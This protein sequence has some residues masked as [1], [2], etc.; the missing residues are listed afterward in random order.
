MFGKSLGV[1]VRRLLGGAVRDPR[2]AICAPGLGDM[3]SVYD[4]VDPASLGELAS[5]VTECAL[6]VVFVPGP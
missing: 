5:A 2:A 6:K 4:T 3:R 1:S